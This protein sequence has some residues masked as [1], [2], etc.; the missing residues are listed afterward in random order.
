MVSFIYGLLEKIGYTHPFHPP[1]SHLPIG[2]LGG[3]F[4]LAL[5]ALLFRRSILPSIA[6]HR[7]ILLALIFIFPAIFF[8][9][10]DWQHY[11]FGNWLF[12][13]KM[14]IVLSGV[15]LILLLMAFFYGRKGK[16]ESRVV[17]MIYAL[18]LVTLTGLGYYGSELSFAEKPLIAPKMV[19][20]FQAGQKLFAGNC[21]ACHPQATDIAAAPQIAN[22]EGFLTFLRDP[23]RPDGSPAEMPRF[24]PEQLSNEQIMDLYHYVIALVCAQMPPSAAK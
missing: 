19:F 24:T 1:W 2:L 22:F 12:P 6:Y 13:I 14:K 5:V 18:C 16:G 20:R 21:N 3:A 11:Y 17:L 4:I 23:R 9:Y 15:L 10:T 8:G 7:L